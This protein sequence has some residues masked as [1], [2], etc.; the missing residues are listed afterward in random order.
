[1]TIDHKKISQQLTELV[2]KY[3]SDEIKS[4]DRYY[5]ILT[6]TKSIWE[7][8]DLVWTKFKNK[9]NE[10]KATILNEK[11]TL[12][13]LELYA[14]TRSEVNFYHSFENHIYFNRGDIGLIFHNFFR[15]LSI[16]RLSTSPYRPSQG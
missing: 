15:Y 13:F 1:M 9:S 10:Y 3:A 6:N 12:E 16:Q 11:L 2:D 4:N 7:N 5:D 14:R 8:T